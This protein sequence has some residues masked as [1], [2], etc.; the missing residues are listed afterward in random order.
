MRYKKSVT[1]EADDSR[2]F[3]GN[4]DD[5]ITINDLFG[6][7][8]QIFG[9]AGNDAI[10][11]WLLLSLAATRRISVDFFSSGYLDVSVLQF[12]LLPYEFRQQ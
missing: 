3:G 10:T 2:I 1:L 9:D 11:R 6:T 7:G 4:G 8:N 5:T 12:A